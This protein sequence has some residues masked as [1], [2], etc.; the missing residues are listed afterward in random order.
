MLASVGQRNGKFPEHELGAHVFREQ[1]RTDDRQQPGV[2]GGRRMVGGEELL[3]AR[4]EE[5]WLDHLAGSSGNRRMRIGAGKA[6]PQ[7][8]MSATGTT[9][10]A[11]PPRS[12][13]PAICRV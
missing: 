9:G 3:V 13:S 11:M 1:R 6:V 7:A 10:I 8:V 12:S 5:E 4:S 2:A